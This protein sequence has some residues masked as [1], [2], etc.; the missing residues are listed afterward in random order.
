M[1]VHVAASRAARFLVAHQSPEGWWR[2][3]DNLPVGASDGWVTAYVGRALAD[4]AAAGIESAAAASARRAAAWLRDVRA[5][6][7]G[8]GYNAQTGPDADSTA[9]AIALLRACDIPVGTAD[10]A[11]LRGR[12]RDN[13]GCATYDR[14]DAWGVA[15][16]DVTPVAFLALPDTARAEIAPGVRRFIE[17]CRN[18]DGTWPAYWWRTCHYSTYWNLRALA[19]IDGQPPLETPGCD[20]GEAGSAF[21]LAFAV[22]ASALAG[23]PFSA[24]LRRLLRQQSD[25]GSW[26]GAANLRVTDPRCLRPWETPA[27]LLY[28]DTQ[29]L[30]TT[31][32]VLLVLGDLVR[33]SDS[34]HRHP[35]G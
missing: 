25:D 30:L 24:R 13:G 31:A 3:Y 12:F 33:R 19:A 35:A 27:G 34:R 16:V 17:V 20:E 21:D 15:H 6:P 11:W 1:M 32:S 22:G 26:P 5:Y 7:A 29:R 8:W 14:K 28:V 4:A 18:A 9:H 10:V 2:D 23:G